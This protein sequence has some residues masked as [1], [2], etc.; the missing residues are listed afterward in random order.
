MSGVDVLD[1]IHTLVTLVRIHEG[2]RDAEV[3]ALFGRAE[4]CCMAI[5][6]LADAAAAMNRLAKGPVG[7]VSQADKKAIVDRMDAAL[8]KVTGGGK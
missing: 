4:A 3:N 7:G 2:N 1:T 8:A 6:E 5:A